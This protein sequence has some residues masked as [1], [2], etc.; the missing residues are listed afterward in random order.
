MIP[1]EDSWTARSSRSTWANN[2]A[3]I[4]VFNEIRNMG[5]RI[6]NTLK[7]RPLEALQL[8][9]CLIATEPATAE[10]LHLVR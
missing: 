7:R 10:L 9:N 3:G 1:P 5:F 2:P 6:C 8:K 4:L